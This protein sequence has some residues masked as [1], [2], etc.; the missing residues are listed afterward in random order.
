[1][2]CAC[3]LY[4]LCLFK[5]LSS[6]EPLPLKRVA[7]MK[8]ATTSYRRLR[9]AVKTCCRSLTCMD[10]KL[11]LD[12]WLLHLMGAVLHYNPKIEISS[13]LQQIYRYFHF[14]CRKAKVEK[15]LKTAASRINLKDS[16]P[17][18]F[19]LMSECFTVSLT[20]L[21]NYPCLISGRDFATK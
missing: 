2:Y 11:S 21:G 12:Q 15:V 20:V 18:C 17:T 6:E 13:Y 3:W 5:S 4:I 10:R 9:W 8:K 19:K 14:K 1:M 7:W 16:D